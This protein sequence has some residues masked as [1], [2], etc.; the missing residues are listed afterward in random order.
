MTGSFTVV[1][2]RDKLDMELLRTADESLPRVVRHMNSSIP[3]VGLLDGVPIASC[4]VEPMEG[5]HDIVNFAVAS[6]HQNQGYGRALL[7]HVTDYL[8]QNG[9]RYVDIGCGNANLRL[10]AMY[11]RAGFRVTAVWFDFYLEDNKVARVENAI[12]NRDMIRFRAD[13]LEQTP[14]T[15]G[16][17]ASGRT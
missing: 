6:E 5:Y 14:E 2:D 3:F 11:Q 15:T 17:D 8:R 13:L 4:L 16:Y 9:G 7:K 1:M 10:Y 12:I